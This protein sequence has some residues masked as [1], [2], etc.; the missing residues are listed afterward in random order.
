[1]SK[2]KPNEIVCLSGGAL[3]ADYYFKKACEHFGI[4]YI[5][6]Y[7]GEQSRFNAP[8]GTNHITE[9]DEHE[10]K[11]MA[12]LAAKHN[13]GYKYS[14]MSDERLVRNWAQVKHTESV[15]AIGTLIDKGEKV[16]PNVVND[17]RIALNPCVTGGTGYAVTMALFHKKPVYVFDQ[18]RKQWFTYD[19]ESNQWIYYDGI[20][21][22][23]KVFTGIG[24][25]KLNTYGLKA[26]ESLFNDYFGE[27]L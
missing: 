17:N 5:G 20:P 3:G 25:R 12:A 1:M 10:G 27:S 19:Y 21:K 13:W 6:W 4:K 23:T 26:I 16:F 9:I 7:L 24:S 8:Y 15:F 18:D 22:L 2:L 11:I 14:S